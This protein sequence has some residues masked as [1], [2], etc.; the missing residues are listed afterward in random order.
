[1][2]PKISISN[3]CCSFE[4]PL[5]LKNHSRKAAQL[6]STMMIIIIIIIINVSWV[7]NQHIR[8]ISEWSCETQDWSNGFWKFSFGF[9]ATAAFWLD[10][11]LQHTPTLRYAT[12]CTLTPTQFK[13]DYTY[14]LHKYNNL[15]ATTGYHPMHI[16]GICVFSL[17]IIYCTFAYYCVCIYVYIM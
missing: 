8:M 4:L 12:H 2:L 3:K 13:L 15:S 17:C 11:T 5:K 9:L 7:P 6:F 1:M 16:H 10:Y 14:T